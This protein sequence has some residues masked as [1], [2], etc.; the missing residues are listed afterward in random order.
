MRRNVTVNQEKGLLTFN[1][2]NRGIYSI[3]LFFF[4]AY[5]SM[6]ASFAA[7]EIE[8]SPDS[9]GK[10]SLL[11]KLMQED[12]SDGM[13]SGYGFP[14]VWDVPNQTD[15]IHGIIVMLE[16]NTRINDI[17]LNPGDWIGGFYT[18]D[19]GELRCGG[20]DFLLDTS[21]IIFPLFK[22]DQYTPGVKDGFSYG[23]TIY[24]KLFSWT[25]LKS[26]DVDVIEFNTSGQYTSTDK[27]YPLG[28]SQ[29]VDLQA[30]VEM[31]FYINADDNPIC[32]GNQLYLSGEEFIGS[33]G[34]YTFE[35]T[36]DPPGFFSTSQVPPPTTPFETTTYFLSVHDGP[37]F[38]DQQVTITVNDLPQANAGPNGTVCGNESFSLSGTALNHENII[39]ASSGNG[40]FD[41]PVSLNTSYSP[42]NQDIQN[43]FAILTLIAHPLNPCL[44]NA[45]DELSLQVLPLPIVDPGEDISACGNDVIF[46]DANGLYYN[47]ITWTT[48]GNGVFSNPNS[49]VTQYTPGTVDLSE[50]EATITVC[51][52]A[53]SPC[54][55]TS[56]GDIVISYLVGPSCNAPSSR[57]K[58]ENVQVP[59]AGSAS[60]NNGIL[61]TTQGD[62]YFLNPSVMNTK[63]VAGPIDR[64]NGGTIV[65]LN[66]L[67]I[68]P[69]ST[70][71]TKN[72]NVV[73]K[74]LPDVDAGNTNIVCKDSYLQLDASVD[75]TNNF[76][77]EILEGD[78]TFDN[79]NSLTAKYFPGPGDI[80]SGSFELTLFAS[81]IY[82]CATSESDNLMV[83]VVDNPLVDIT[84]AD[85]QTVCE[86]PPFEVNAEAF[87]FGEI[88]WETSGDGSFVNA[89]LLNTHYVPGPADI[90]SGQL[91]N[92]SIAVSPISPCLI[93]AFS[94][95]DV[96]FSPD[97]L[98]NAGNDIEICGVESAQLQG[99]AQ[100]FSGV[101]WQTNGDGAFSDENILQ[102]TYTPGNNDIDAGIAILTLNAY[103]INPCV[104]VASSNMNLSI[105]K[106]PDVNVGN[107]ATICETG[108]Y[109]LGNILAENYSDLIWTTSG[110]GIF[111]NPVIKDPVYFIG[112]QDKINGSVE[113][114]LLLDP[115]SP[116][117]IAQYDSKTLTIAKLASADAGD[118]A[119]IC[120]IENYQLGG[121]AENYNTILWE[122]NGDGIFSN[123]SILD[124]VYT[125]GVNDIN[126]GTVTL[127][128][129]ALA[130]NPC[131]FDASDEV[132]LNIQ[133]AP[134]I[135][136]GNDAIIC[137]TS[138]HYLGGVTAL[139]Y[140]TLNWTTSGDGT[141]SDP[142]MKNPVYAP[143]G[144]DKLIGSVILTLTGFAINPC[145]VFK[146]DAKELTIIKLPVAIAGEDGVVCESGTY[147][148]DGTAT[149]FASVLWQTNGDGNFDNA[150]L[151]DPVYTPGT[152]DI[153]VGFVTLTMNVAA[154]NPC[155]INS[156]DDLILDIQLEPVV[157]A[158]N[159]A[160]ICET[161]THILNGA[162]AEN[163]S[164]LSW[165]SSGDG[166]FNNPNLINPDYTPGPGDIQNGS[167][168]LTLICDAINP[169][170]AIISDDKQLTII[171]L[172]TANA[173]EN[174]QICENGTYQLDGTATNYS[175]LL[176]ESSGDGTFSNVAILNPV[177][178]PGVSDIN[179]GAVTL[180]MNVLAINPCTINASDEASITIQLEPMVNAGSDAEICE[181]GTYYLGSATAENYTTL[182]WGTS[183]DG[184]FDNPNI[185]NP[186]YTPG[187]GDI[188][189]GNVILTLTGTSV[190]PCI[191]A[192]ESNMTLNIQVAPVINAGNDAT[193][194]ENSTHYLGGVTAL[195]YSTL[196]WT[197]SG[198]GTFSNPGMKNP[199]YAPGGQ[200]KIT[201]SAILTLVGHAVDP[202]TIYEEDDMGL[203]IISLAT[204]SAGEDITACGETELS[205]STTNSNEL[206]WETYGDGNFNNTA[207]ANPVYFPGPGDISNLS[208]ELTISAQPL[209]PCSI[210][211]FDVMTYYIDVPQIV[212][213]DVSDMEI[214]TDN[215]LKF[216]FEAESVTPGE[217]SWFFNN[218]I[219]DGQITSILIINNLTPDNAGYYQCVYL[220]GCGEVESGVALV[221]ILENS[222][223]QFVVPQGW[224][225][226]S[227]YVVPNN[228]AMEDVFTDVVDDLVLISDN[229]GFYWPAQN[230]NTLGD[231]S[232]STGYK[233]KMDASVGLDVDGFIRYPSQELTIPAGWSYLPVNAICAFDV[234]E[235]F[236]QMPEITMIK[237]IAQTGIYWPE[238]NINTLEDLYPGKAY[239][240]LNRSG[241]A[242]TL[243]YPKCDGLFKLTMAETIE[244]E[245]P[246]NEVVKTPSTHV[247]G[248]DAAALSQFDEG[249]IIGAFTNDGY[250]AGVLLVDQPT[251]SQTLVAFANDQMTTARDGFEDGEAVTYKVFR[252]ST[253]EEF[254]LD[255]TYVAQSPNSG[256]F[257]H[258]GIS[259][260]GEVEFKTSSTGGNGLFG[261]NMLMQVYPNPSTGLINIELK[262]D[263]YSSGKIFVTN[264]NGQLV[265]ESEFD[266][267][268]SATSLNIDL[269]NLIKGVYYL[270]LTSDEFTKTGKVILE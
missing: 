46:L 102:P 218:E 171:N 111:S 249:D 93:P 94:S 232:V 258:N 191:I 204:A 155:T 261:K 227:S 268:T 199:V 152:N 139:N 184:G 32:I 59:M 210:A 40:V 159:N 69:C 115:V 107:D 74:P 270:R 193:I 42:G 145:T 142:G 140:S 55:G 224:S 33:G 178:T 118:D 206:L 90:L 134:V 51:A 119:V 194:C 196:N 91:V 160:A 235:L 60:N 149:N 248:F 41:D 244:V 54:V 35:W 62:G 213:D 86:T 47:T 8:G 127:T 26:Y 162:I 16:A 25:T 188:L 100:H 117:L 222:T 211:A 22:D 135:N 241:G 87:Y 144:Q 129:N 264:I 61:W 260:I 130:I 132:S 247:F 105:Q 214:F 24:F 151:P 165:V 240:I 170:T 131:T 148:L 15:A 245:N 121:I 179:D 192:V 269:T 37:L 92:L 39:W 265:Y 11:E 164:T 63:Y 18:D 113:L 163:Y 175:A 146:E 34:P 77:W 82:P 84:T 242:V 125:P 198:D 1:T 52:S 114:T 21:N 205:G 44:A 158:G 203:T 112:A 126:A 73:L 153:N 70:T 17:P 3:L 57:T 104:V 67:P 262:G 166:T 49:S 103:A 250:C 208:V 220:N 122:T 197:T 253:N 7:P 209:A 120:G 254:L 79:A 168:T 216:T 202:C 156:N 154:I 219:I 23:E 212:S 109:Y 56:C 201:G 147:Q 128:L 65:T 187:N 225:G 133:V 263:I 123:N 266:H 161:D 110:D 97:P 176:W 45:E 182:S 189:E 68:S 239:S 80:Q 267:L 141:F 6:G 12:G 83:D 233:I 167:A 246:W 217:Y 183:G 190:S 66:A 138:T 157:N 234:V 172:A 27:W 31:D 58:C 5:G 169:C 238:Y 200:D 255:V 223:H 116:C 108:N 72:V 71:A 207:I 221:Q 173:G 2:I 150:T 19:N 251:G 195:N 237:D 30:Q 230:I 95:I 85:N 76:H 78:G 185:K 180:T 50:G 20:A 88:L 215:T 236:S 43:G 186:V 38:S 228:P 256:L 106:G 13:R 229:V 96:T 9:T 28:L 252:N 226:I 257:A 4:I 101:V 29:I 243:T 137:E 98:A 89:S 48:S 36:S 177:Y 99:V 174:G 124:P 231:W 259:M 181:T 75:H 53:T 136:A 64:E 14:P 81:P 143:G 10:I